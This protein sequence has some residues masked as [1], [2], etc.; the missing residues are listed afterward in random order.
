MNLHQAANLK[1]YIKDSE[2][3]ALI[4]G[5]PEY[6]LVPTSKNEFKLKGLEGFKINI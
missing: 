3:K 5:Q 4:K 2:L 1:V 6:T